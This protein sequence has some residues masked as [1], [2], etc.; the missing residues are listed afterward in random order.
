MDTILVVC[1]DEDY[2][3]NLICSLQEIGASV[4]GPVECDGTALA[5]AAQTSPNLAILAD[6]PTGDRDAEG[7]ARELHETWGVRSLVLEGAAE[8]PLGEQPWL[9]D[10]E[11]LERLIDTLARAA[12][13]K[14]Q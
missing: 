12:A 11:T 6:A 1:R 3:T 7:L 8:R 9:P 14:L 5:L 10:P 2:S 13:S 4:I